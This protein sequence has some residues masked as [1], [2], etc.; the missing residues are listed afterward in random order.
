[1]TRH[2]VLNEPG[3]QLRSGLRTPPRLT[4]AWTALRRRPGRTTVHTRLDAGPRMPA[5]TSRLEDRPDGR[6]LFHSA[7]R[8]RLLRPRSRCN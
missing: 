2:Q 7:H 5:P 4:R 6:P 1:M 3:G 8:P